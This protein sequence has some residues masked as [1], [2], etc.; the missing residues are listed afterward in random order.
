MNKLNLSKTLQ[1]YIKEIKKELEQRD[2]Q[3]RKKAG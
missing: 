2:E 1:T 3:T